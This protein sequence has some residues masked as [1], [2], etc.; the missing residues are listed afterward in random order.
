MELSPDPARAQADYAMIYIPETAAFWLTGTTAP[1][2]PGR[3]LD[4]QDSS[5][6]TAGRTGRLIRSDSLPIAACAVLRG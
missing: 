4:N 6:A 2:T 3:R 5:L 1:R